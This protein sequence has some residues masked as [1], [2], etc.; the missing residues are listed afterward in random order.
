MNSNSS[1]NI[2]K[3]IARKNNINE[4]QTMK[5]VRNQ[6]KFLRFVME[7]ELNKDL[8]IFPTVRLPKFGVFF[9]KYKIINKS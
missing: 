4:D 1:K 7:N 8:K 5:I 2:I 6:F 3:D 9:V